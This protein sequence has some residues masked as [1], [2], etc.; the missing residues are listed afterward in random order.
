MKKFFKTQLEAI[1]W[2]SEKAQNE[3]HFEILREELLF[4]HIYT[5]EYFVHL[6][7]LEEDVAWLDH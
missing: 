7:L 1:Q 2:I 4:N 5:N 6:V 3:A